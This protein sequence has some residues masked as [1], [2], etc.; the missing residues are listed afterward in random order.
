MKLTSAAWS[1]LA[2]T[3]LVAASAVPAASAAASTHAAGHSATRHNA[4]R[5]ATTPAAWQTVALPSSV[6]EHATLGGVSAAN[7][8]AAWAVGADAETAYQKGAPLIL[9]WNGSTWSKVV[10]SGVA[11]PGYLTSVAAAS[12]SDAWVVGTDKLGAVVLHW[13]GTSWKSVSFPDSS[14]ATVSG[15][16]AGPRGTAWLV[17]SVPA[18]GS[19]TTILVEEWNGKAWH[20]VKTGLGGGCLSSVEV[21][22]SGDVYA[23]GKNANNNND[24]PLVADEHGGVWKLLP[25]TN[26][27]N[28]NAVLGVSPTDVWAV[29]LSAFLQA[30]VYDAIVAHWNGKAWTLLNS[31]DNV[32]SQDWSISAGKS[33]QPQWVGAE[34]GLEPS[35]TLYAYYNGTSWSNVSG[36]TSLTG[37]YDAITVTAHIPG[38]GATWG[39]GGSVNVSSA[40]ELLPVKAYIEYNP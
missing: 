37:A 27:S 32:A 25:S 1:A 16:A 33:G 40:G 20:V 39:V 13:N 35:S 5:A 31:P 3:A 12:A 15:V 34:A 14:R 8:S 10:L 4:A 21:S 11:G 28:V 36:A 22:P 9:R 19:N 23:T 30:G 38:T 24:Q 29:G 18:S 7:A 6:K 26:I 2:A 17:G